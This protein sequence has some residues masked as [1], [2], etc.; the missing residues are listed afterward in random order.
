MN[1][2][3]LRPLAF[4]VIAASPIVAVVVACGSSSSGDDSS[5]VNVD[6]SADGTLL[7]RDGSSADASVA[8][9]QVDKTPPC[10]NGLAVMSDAVS[11]AKTIGICSNATTDGFGLVSAFFSKGFDQLDAAADAHFDAATYVIPSGLTV[12]AGLLPKF[13]DVIKPREGNLLGLL[14]TGYAR[15][16]DGTDGGEQTF[17]G[18]PAL[19]GVDYPT[20]H[21][22]PGFP[23]ASEGC[24]TNGDANDMID[25]K[26]TLKAPADAHGFQFDYD[27]YASDWPDYVCTQFND[28]FIAYVNSTTVH[29]D[30]VAFDAKNQPITVN[31]PFIDHCTIDAGVGCAGGEVPLDAGVFNSHCEAGT[32]ELSG[33]GYGVTAPTACKKSTV[34]SR[35]AS[36]GWLTTTVPISPGE[37]FTLELMIW[38]NGDAYLDSSA[39]VDNF[40]W[41]SSAPPIVTTRAK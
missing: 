11:F 5:I 22:P 12:Q 29:G 17:M 9:G 18:G 4:V 40:Q 10:D 13:G 30:N 25:V 21:A 28:S 36:T 6:G 7:G 15:E 3:V 33:T 34:S 20:G 39:L 19:D 37:T 1:K 32:A 2:P 23:K 16:F 27:F 41:I 35:G 31:I 8:D 24:P 38:D 14:S 26:L